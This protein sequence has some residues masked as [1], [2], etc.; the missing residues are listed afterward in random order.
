M[1]PIAYIIIGTAGG[2][3]LLLVLLLILVIVCCCICCRKKW[4]YKYCRVDFSRKRVSWLQ[5]H[6]FIIILLSKCSLINKYSWQ[7]MM[8]CG[9][10][11]LEKMKCIDWF[12]KISPLKNPP[13]TISIII[14]S[15]CISCLVH[16]YCYC[17]DNSHKLHHFVALL[18][19]YIKLSQHSKVHSHLNIHFTPLG[20]YCR[21]SMLA[22]DIW[23]DWHIYFYR[24]LVAKLLYHK[25]L[26]NKACGQQMILNS[27][28]ACISRDSCCD[29]NNNYFCFTI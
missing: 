19:Y 2:G 1:V 22:K 24:W 21:Y 29:Y 8:I 7:S 15:D 3:G 28:M 16:T 25:K 10:V 14:A 26:H 4:V 9:K 27:S 12:M 20:T 18:Q 13:C 11:S 23:L 5:L 17:K 6:A